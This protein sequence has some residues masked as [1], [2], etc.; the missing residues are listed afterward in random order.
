MLGRTRSGSLRLT[1]DARGLAFDLDLPDTQAGRDVL[2]LA[3]RGDVGG[4][5]FGFTVRDQHR[6]GDWREL[7]AVEL[8][9][10]SVVSTWPACPGTVVRARAALSGHPQLAHA[11]RIVRIM[12]AQQ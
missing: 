9:E 2:A 5:S 6:K 8:L 4:M 12:E 11:A 10:V 3:E 7:R 1:E